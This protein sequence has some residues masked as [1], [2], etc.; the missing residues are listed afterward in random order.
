MSLPY[1]RQFSRSYDGFK[2][3]CLFIIGSHSE[4]RGLSLLLV[5]GPSGHPRGMAAGQGTQAAGLANLLPPFYLGF[6]PS[7]NFLR[8]TPPVCTP[9]PGVS[10]LSF[11]V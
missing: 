2:E 8:R 9:F 5:K 7:L 3:S 4:A 11:S 6:I 1:A 10:T